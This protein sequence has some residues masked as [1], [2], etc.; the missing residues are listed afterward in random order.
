MTLRIL[1]YGLLRRGGTLHGLLAGA[2]YL[3][4]V[5]VPGY[6]LFHMGEYPAAVPGKGAIVAE[7]WELASADALSALDRAEGV[8]TLYRRE[9][10]LDAWLYVYAR[11]PGGAPRIASGDW[12]S[13]PRPPSSP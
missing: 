2:R 11:P 7:L 1:V 10:V 9:R 13:P 4:D 8:P 6:D 3:E 12:L 5:R